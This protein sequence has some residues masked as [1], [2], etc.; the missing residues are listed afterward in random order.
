MPQAEDVIESPDRTTRYCITPGEHEILP[1]NATFYQIKVRS[2][3][4]LYRWVWDDPICKWAH[5]MPTSAFAALV[6][7]NGWKL[8]ARKDQ[9]PPK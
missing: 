3:W 9:C 5:Y 7:Y 6:N 2:I 1:K 8:V 4:T